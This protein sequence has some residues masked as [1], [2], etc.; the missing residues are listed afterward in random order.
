[1]KAD[2][3]QELFERS[4]DAILVIVAERF[5]NCNAATVKMLGYKDKRELL[6]THPSQLS[7]EF[8]ADGQLSYLKANEMMAIAFDKGSH[9]F[10][11]DHVRAN[12]EVFPVEV[13]L[14]AIPEKKQKTLHVVWRDI[15][16]RKKEYAAFRESRDQL[17]AIFNATQDGILVTD[18]QTKTFVTGNHA[19]CGMLGYSLEE[20]VEIDVNSIHPKKDLFQIV[21]QF[22]ELSSKQIE[23]AANIRVLRKDGSVFFA[24]IST[25][26]ATIGGNPCMVEIFRDVTE[27]KAVEEKSR[28]AQKLE[29]LGTLAGGI[30]HDF[31]NILAA[32]LGYSEL[33]L[34]ELP[35]DS[36]AYG[37]L[38]KVIRATNRAAEL[39]KQIL[40]FSRHSSGN[41]VP[42]RVQPVIREVLELVR[43][44][45]P[46][47]IVIEQAIDEH[48]GQVIADETQIHQVL[49]NLCTNAFHAME[50]RGGTLD[51]R[52][53]QV[54]LA[55]EDEEVA[56]YG[57]SPGQYLKLEVGDN[58]V[59]IDEQVLGHIFDPYFTT[60]PQGKGSGLG[61][62]VVYGIVKDHGGIVNVRSNPGG[63]VTFTVI[64]PVVESSGEALDLY[65]QNQP[66]FGNERILFVDDEEALAELGKEMLGTLGYVVCCKTDSRVAFEVFRDNPH[67]YDLVITDQTMPHLSGSEL[68]MKMMEIRPDIP[69]ILCTG[70]SSV[71][72][73]SEPK[74]LGIRAV[75][76]KPVSQS[77]LAGMVRKILDTT[78]PTG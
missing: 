63:G 51:I 46:A 16:G 24:D 19:I 49:M 37:N 20:I 61:L 62:A 27:R 35:A 39:V 21:N 71:I 55:D 65:A 74:A 40:A 78:R 73:G 76:M 26:L 67:D 2:R 25:S 44:S 60:K 64:L 17:K 33:T 43:A 8:Q 41:F 31:N 50:D 47:T 6:N 23:L 14:T 45:L 54:R 66:L 10:E 3:Y 58:G 72:A 9:R 53:R 22:E 75:V 7:P 57:L 5:V 48:C 68:S 38:T 56:R 29:A 34:A 28:N 15:T 69:I 30:A 77:R 32:I 59:G 52:L 12:G 42:L 36:K 18:V 4:A 1:M 70:Y 13:L 11:W